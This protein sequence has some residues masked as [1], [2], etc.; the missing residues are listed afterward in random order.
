MPNPKFF[1]CIASKRHVVDELSWP[2]GGKWEQ[3]SR[4][5]QSELRLKDIQRMIPKLNHR[6]LHYEHPDDRVKVKIGEIIHNYLDADRNWKVLIEINDGKPIGKQ[7]LQHVRKKILRGLSLSHD[8]ETL[9]PIEVSLVEEG[10]RY[11]TGI[12]DELKEGDDD[13]FPPTSSH[14]LNDSKY[15]VDPSDGEVTSALPVS[16]APRVINAGVI[17]MSA[18][19]AGYAPPPQQ[20]QHH[21]PP[22]VQPYQQQPP[23][24]PA[25]FPQ[26]PGAPATQPP[27]PSSDEPN[28][29]LENSQQLIERLC[30][31]HSIP[32]QQD[33]KSLLQLL[34][35]VGKSQKSLEAKLELEKKN[36]GE[37]SKM[38]DHLLRTILNHSEGKNAD[39]TTAASSDPESK[40]ASQLAADD[41]KAYM[42]FM[43]PKLIQASA[44]LSA[45]GLPQSSS[46]SS[47]SSSSNDFVPVD[48]PIPH[49]D[50]SMYAQFRSFQEVVGSSMGGGGSGIP[51]YQPP[52]Q[53]QYLHHQQQQQY[54]QPRTMQASASAKR[55]RYA[56]QPSSSGGAGGWMNDASLMPS[57]RA[58]FQET[59]NAA[60]SGFGD[61]IRRADVTTVQKTR[62]YGPSADEL[63]SLQPPM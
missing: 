11:E 50:P 49:Y 57:T 30:M 47:S 56:E 29:S 22:P 5:Q 48:N 38:F 33:R 34:T 23:P 8:T 62:Q 35:N 15:K 1:G 42:S 46:S 41:P 14:Q 4:D 58:I 24:Q 26:Q 3:L 39:A 21:Q 60:I 6:P 54:H 27:P 18:T 12:E 13:A 45:Y 32:S 63:K 43:M 19:N 28:I 59:Q 40:T 55:P 17:K 25:D 7:M 31:S 44:R 37:T 53:Q 61:T 9:E 10:F 52:Q 51:F 36:S 20:P 16:N 2:K